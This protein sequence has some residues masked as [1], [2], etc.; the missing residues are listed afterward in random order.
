M[1]TPAG[2][3]WAQ[4]ALAPR[5]SE[6]WSLLCSLFSTTQEPVPK[7]NGIATAPQT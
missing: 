4:T 2:V 3:Y 6:M 1:V 5:P 7:D